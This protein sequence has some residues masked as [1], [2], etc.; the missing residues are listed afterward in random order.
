MAKLTAAVASIGYHLPVKEAKG[1]K[2][3]KDWQ[4][5]MVDMYGSSN[6]LAAAL[7]KKDQAAA[8]KA[9]V[10]LNKCCNACH[11]QFQ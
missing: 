4:G 3:L 10:A 8:K 5:W 1:G 2:R 11:A 9:A 7:K 6:D